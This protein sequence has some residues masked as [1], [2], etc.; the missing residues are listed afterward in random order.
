[1]I[2]GVCAGKPAAHSGGS[3][4]PPARALL[5]GAAWPTARP[6]S[7]RVAGQAPGRHQE[8]V[9]EVA[10]EGV[11]APPEGRIERLQHEVAPAGGVDLRDRH[12][13]AA[14]APPEATQYGVR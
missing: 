7:T 13:A 4:I 10:L 2:K 5:A 6:S 11:F 8:R 14:E 9:E 3:G 12:E 1:M